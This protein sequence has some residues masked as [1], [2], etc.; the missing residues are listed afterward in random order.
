MRRCDWASLDW[1]RPDIFQARNL[2]S[3]LFAAGF[4]F[5]C[6]SNQTECHLTELHTKGCWRI[7][8]SG[9]LK[10]WCSIKQKGGLDSVVCDC[11]PLW[12]PSQ[13]AKHHKS[14][15]QPSDFP[16]HQEF[17]LFLVEKERKD[18]F[19]INPG[20]QNDLKHHIS[21]VRARSM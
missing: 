9:W 14:S 16:S 1:L 11:T 12:R 15:S 3:R 13:Q 4:I 20:P 18:F 2:F 8:R 6:G 21:G 5:G 17:V 19:P 10:R 7:T